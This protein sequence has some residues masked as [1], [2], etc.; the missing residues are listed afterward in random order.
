MHFW[1]RTWKLSGVNFLELNHLEKDLDVNS[2]Q[3]FWRKIR[4][5]DG[6]ITFTIFHLKF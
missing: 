6:G 3:H 1:D 2:F 4:V 5:W